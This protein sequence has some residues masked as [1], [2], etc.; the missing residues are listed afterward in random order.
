[1]RNHILLRGS[2]C[3]FHL[4]HCHT[5]SADWSAHHGHCQIQFRIRR[6]YYLFRFE[7][8]N[9]VCPSCLLA[10]SL[11]YFFPRLGFATVAVILGGQT[12][13]AVRPGTLSL[14]GGVVIV[15]VL[16]LIPCFIGY[17]VIHRYE[18]YVWMPVLLVMLFIW[19]LGGTKGGFDVSAQKQFEDPSGRFLAGD[20]LSF[21]GIVFGSFT[22]VSVSLSPSPLN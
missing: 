15:C 13:A 19:G 18:R 14:T 5:R 7:H 4:P 3:R 8:S 17:H 9:T 10:V 16:S 20:V 1:M 12:L 11:I 22:G 2:R 21:G 6:R